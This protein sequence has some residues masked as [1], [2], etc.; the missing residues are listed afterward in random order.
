M[1]KFII[2]T[3]QLIRG[4]KWFMKNYQIWNMEKNKILYLILCLTV[5]VYEKV[6]GFFI[7]P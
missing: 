3:G 7:F 4:T 6:K 2:I 5:K 1:L